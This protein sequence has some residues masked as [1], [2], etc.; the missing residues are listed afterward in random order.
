MLELA[1]AGQERLVAD[2]RREGFKVVP[3]CGR[4]GTALSSHELGDS[5]LI[6]RWPVQ[7]VPGLGLPSSPQRTAP[8]SSILLMGAPSNTFG[9]LPLKDVGRE[10]RD[11]E[12]LWIA[13][14]RTVIKE[15]IQ[16]DGAPADVGLPVQEWSQFGVLHFACH[17]HFVEDRPLDSALR[18]GRDAVRGSELFA[19]KLNGSIVALSA[20][21]LGRRASQY[22]GTEVVSE[23][24]LGL[25]LPLFFAGARALVVSLWDANSRVARDFMVEFHKALAANEKP[26]AAFRKGMLHVQRGLQARWANWCLV[27][28][29]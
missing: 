22:G 28:L 18:L 17:G 11:I 16:A 13:A 15:V 23:E 12:Q 19:I 10:L 7:Y 26:H 3:Y 21:A 27:G 20:C 2:A 25:Y 14:R 1:L 24:W 5:C 9:D 4:C 8:E 29:P 6:A